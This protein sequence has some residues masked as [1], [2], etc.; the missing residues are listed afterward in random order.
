MIF[1]T[2]FDAHHTRRSTLFSRDPPPHAGMTTLTLHET[3]EYE[4]YDTF[5]FHLD[6]SFKLERQKQRHGHDP[7]HRTTA[8]SPRNPTPWNTPRRE[9]AVARRH[10]TFADM[11]SC[12]M[13]AD[14]REVEGCDAEAMHDELGTVYGLDYVSCH[15]P[16]RPKRPGDDAVHVGVL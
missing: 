8:D 16:L 12:C 13:Y 4:L 10:L 9:A 7:R 11:G 1:V 6:R 14:G 3:S 15:S 2:L 5:A